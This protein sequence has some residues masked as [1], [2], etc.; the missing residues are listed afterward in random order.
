MNCRFLKTSLKLKSVMLSMQLTSVSLFSLLTA[1]PS[2]QCRPTG[3]QSPLFSYAGNINCL[4]LASFNHEILHSVDNVAPHAFTVIISSVL[5]VSKLS[6][7]STLLSLTDLVNVFR[8]S[9][10]KWI[11]PNS[12]LAPQPLE[13]LVQLTAVVHV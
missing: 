1:Q 12:F 10:H 6:T 8:S 2:S 7:N 5:L 4:S 13:Y 9:F 3:K 11:L